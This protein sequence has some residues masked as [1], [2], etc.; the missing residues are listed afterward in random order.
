MELALD[1]KFRRRDTAMLRVTMMMRSARGR[2]AL[3]RAEL[4]RAGCPWRPKP[5]RNDLGRQLEMP[6]SMSQIGLQSK[7]AGARPARVRDASQL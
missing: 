7:R 6:A 4:K 3:R 5:D 1:A 2:A